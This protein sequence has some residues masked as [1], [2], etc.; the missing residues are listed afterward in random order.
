MSAGACSRYCDG[1]AG[2]E[3][4][5]VAALRHE[6]ACVAAEHVARTSP[7]GAVLDPIGVGVGG[8]FVVVAKLG[9]RVT[10]VDV[11]AHSCESFSSLGGVYQKSKP[12]VLA[13]WV[14]ASAS[15]ARAASCQRCIC[16]AD[17]V[18]RPPSLSATVFSSN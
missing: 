14:S 6:C 12:C 3:A 13:M 11:V 4:G 7:P 18:Q 15:M 10:I 17:T 9:L 2:S 5:D 16:R 8:L 1:G